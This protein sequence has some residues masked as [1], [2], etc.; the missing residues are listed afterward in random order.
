MT[1]VILVRHGQS[2]A[3]LNLYFA[4][5][6]N[7][8]L[9]ELGYKQA[10]KFSHWVLKNYKIDKIYSSDLLRAYN[11]AK[12]T[13]EKLGY[14]IIKDINFREINAGKW[15]GLKFE[16][17]LID[18]PEDYGMFINDIGNSRC[19][20]GESVRELSV[21]VL[22]E[23]KKVCEENDG[24]TILVATHATPIRSIQTILQK[25]D[26][27]YAKDVPW[28]PNASATVLKYEKGEFSF[29]LIGYNDYLSDIKSELP[30]NIV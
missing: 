8:N 11:T 20:D 6:C 14:N 28:T 1:N 23:L 10:E 30:S 21:R 27:S 7:P 12:P 24:K 15:E 18:Y 2:D 9:T 3:N 29:E 17:L 22:A 26:I 25:G 5:H 13:A 4:G 16:Q 19:T